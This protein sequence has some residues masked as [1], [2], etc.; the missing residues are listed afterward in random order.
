MAASLVS[1]STRL[2]AVT[3]RC[4]ASYFHCR[5]PSRLQTTGQFQNLLVERCG[6]KQ[7]VGVVKLNRPRLLNALN[8]ALMTELGVALRQLDQDNNIGCIIITGSD[9]AFSIGADIP[10]MSQKTHQDVMEQDF[11]S[12]FYCVSKC[13][14][15]IIA[16]VNG[17]VLGGGCE[18]AMMCDIIYAGDKA[19]FSQPEIALGTIPG[20][21]GTQRLIRAV[22]K[23]RAMEMILMGNRLSAQEAEKIGLVSKVMPAAE[24]LSAAVRTAEKIAGF[25]HIAVAMCKEAV[26]ASQELPLAEGLHL[27]QRL[28]EATFSTNDQTEGMTAFI[29]KRKPNFTHD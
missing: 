18:V 16:A 26:N 28:A 3:A 24:V 22:S 11:P 5:Q 10:E 25:S 14:K 21:G 23:S 29:E 20:A 15:P 8:D 2:K 6:E 1:V 4:I 7:N 13:R 9:R 17:Y 12:K 19:Q 27:E